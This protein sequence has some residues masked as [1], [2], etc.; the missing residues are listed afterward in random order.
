MKLILRFEDG[1]ERE[2]MEILPSMLEKGRGS[3]LRDMLYQR[4]RE[5]IKAAQDADER[6]EET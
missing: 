3:W 6:D 5:A 2:V 4:V 1:I